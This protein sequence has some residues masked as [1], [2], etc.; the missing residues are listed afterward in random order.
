MGAWG[1]GVFDN[2]DAGDWL[3]EYEERG[4]DAVIE[5]F[6]TVRDSHAAGYVELPEGGAAVAAAEAVAFALGR[7]DPEIMDSIAATLS[8]HAPAVA[9]LSDIRSRAR[10][11]L[12]LV[13]EEEA[14]S[15][16]LELWMEGG[17]DGAGDFLAAIAALKARLA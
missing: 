1:A 10:D 16:L 5:A 12:S 6:A 15:E 3:Y 2:D 4:A 7:P 11:A 13:M 17:E 14:T 8:R 9:A